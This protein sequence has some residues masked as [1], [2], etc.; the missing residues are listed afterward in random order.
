MLSRELLV[1]GGVDVV[2]VKGRAV[3]AEGRIK[4]CWLLH[5][6]VREKE[7]EFINDYGDNGG[8]QHCCCVCGIED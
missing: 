3:A 1:E 4:W 7:M 2:C 6:W 5:C 8:Q